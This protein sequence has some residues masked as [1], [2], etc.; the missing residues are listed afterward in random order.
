MRPS[1]RWS[2]I[3]SFLFFAS[4]SFLAAGVLPG[5]ATVPLVVEVHEPP[6]PVRGGGAIQLAYELHLTNFSDR[7]YRL[8]GLEGVSAEDTVGEDTGGEILWRRGEEDLRTSI[9]GAARPGGSEDPLL[10]GPGQR[11]IVFIWAELEE[12]GAVPAALRHRLTVDSDRFDEPRVMSTPA[13]LLD[14]GEVVTLGPPLRGPR[15]YAGGG[16]SNSSHHRRALLPIHGRA[17]L[18]Q[19]YATDWMQFGEDGRLWTE[20]PSCNESWHGYGAEVLAVEDAIVAEIQDGI[21]EN[22]PPDAPPPGSLEELP[23]NYVTLAL[24]E[25]RY[26]HYAHLQPGTLRVREGEK[27]RRGQVLGLLGN[28]GNSTAPHLHFGVIDGRD[29]LTSEGLPYVIDGYEHRDNAPESMEAYEAGAAWS[30]GG[31]RMIGRT[32]ELPLDG[33]VVDF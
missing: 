17:A 2:F 28:S 4:L 13:V 31:D 8:V 12:G 14:N 11:S 9:R 3:L 30:G 21:P 15:W 32:R 33:A 10:I 22:T 26:A 18:A 5:Q 1:R 6:L 29:P 16:P 25:G 24:G 23:G 19:R 20:D 27:V 7:P